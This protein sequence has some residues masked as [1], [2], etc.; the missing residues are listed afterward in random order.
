MKNT[1]IKKVI[2]VDFIGREFDKESE[3]EDSNHDI[4]LKFRKYIQEELI[5]TFSDGTVDKMGTT[6]EIWNCLE[7]T[8]ECIKNIIKI[9]EEE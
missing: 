2:F 7:F 6:K 3:A 9:M 5:R 4:Q 1:L 8:P